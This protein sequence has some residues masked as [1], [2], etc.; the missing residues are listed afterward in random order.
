VQEAQPDYR[1]PHKA[2]IA[3]PSAPRRL[4]ADSHRRQHHEPAKLLIS[5]LKLFRPKNCIKSG[6]VL[7]FNSNLKDVFMRN[8]IRIKNVNPSH[9]VARILCGTVL[10]CGLMSSTAF[11]NALHGFCF[12]PTPTCSDN[13][14]NT[15]TSA[16]SGVNS[17][18]I[19]RVTRP[20]FRDLFAHPFRR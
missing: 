2:I 9:Q 10:A 17:P 7:C 3:A 18:S 5:F 11:A 19:P 20:V 16:D 6:Q 13:G 12:S 15:P 1:V 14:T 8:V 4:C